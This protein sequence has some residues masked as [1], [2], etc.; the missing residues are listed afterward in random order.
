MV[1]AVVHEPL[2]VAGKSQ[3]HKVCDSV[4]HPRP[5]LSGDSVHSL[6][7][8]VHERAVCPD[9]AKRGGLWSVRFLATAVVG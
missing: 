5:G 4:S 8:R 3:L 1:T 2:R 7:G 9:K 6:S